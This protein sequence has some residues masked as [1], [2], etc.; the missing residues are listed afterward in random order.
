MKEG[1]AKK[2]DPA[3]KARMIKELEKE[4][5]FSK[6]ENRVVTINLNDEIVDYFKKLSLKTGK[7]YQILI[8]DALK[9]F[10]D[11]KLEPQTVWKKKS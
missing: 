5:D 4:F 1:G 7:G 8:K 6:V 9:Y 10:I 11:E 3:V 2:T